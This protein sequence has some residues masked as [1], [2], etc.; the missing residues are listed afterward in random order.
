MSLSEPR[1]GV[2]TAGAVDWRAIAFV[3][4]L[5][6]AW[7]TIRPFDD[8]GDAQ[9]FDLSTGREAA[10]YICF[11]ALALFCILQVVGTDRRGLRCLAI[12]PFGGLAAWIGLTCLTSQDAA[13]S[14]KRAA[15]CGFVAIAAATLLLLPRGRLHLASLLALACGAL[16]ALSY[17]G[18]IFMPQYAIHQA[19]DLAEP[20]LAGDW[21]GVFSHKNDAGAI[22]SI[23]V[24]IG[25]FV[26]RSG[27]MAEGCL[28]C[29]FSLLF[30]FMSDGKSSTF[31]CGAT[32]LV[33]L[34]ATRR[35]LGIVSAAAALTPLLALN[36]L[37]IG[38]VAFPQLASVSA[39]LPL[40]ATFTGRTDIW[41]FALTKI[42]SHLFSGYG[43]SAFWNNESLRSAAADANSWVGQAAHAHNGYL[44]AVLSMGLPGLALVL[45]AFVIQ[46]FVDLRRAQRAGADPALVLMLAQIWLFGIYL[47][48]LESFF[49]DRSNP[50]WITFLFALF[51]LRYVACYKITR[52]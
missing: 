22:F 51:G 8:L 41:Q 40:D 7:I 26:A 9:A 37:G 24:F 25:V 10:T 30:V 13:T 5:L 3:A 47:S 43:F 28:L 34:V 21:R 35:G 38:S 2:E 1:V 20:N 23:I 39:S 50:I 14:C 49:F 4:V 15:M 18:V 31:L 12:P 6:L 52:G 44:D 48:A 19:T 27:R 16:L 11:A 42:P 29:A 45:W 46:P 32:I 17:F 36:A 33:S